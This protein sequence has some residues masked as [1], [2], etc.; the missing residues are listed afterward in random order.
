MYEKECSPKYSIITPMYNSFSKMEL[1]LSSFERQNYRNFEIIIVDDC[2][3]D[4]SYERITEYSKRSTLQLKILKTHKNSGPGSARNIGLKNITSEWVLFIDS[5]DCIE[6]NFFETI[7]DNIEDDV[8]ILLF[9]YYKVDRERKYKKETVRNVLNSSITKEDILL[10]GTTS[11]WGK[12]FRVECIINHD[13]YFPELFRYEDWVF[14]VKVI[15]SA[16]KIK[17]IRKP[18]Y[19]YINY[20][21]SVVHVRDRQGC[22][23]ASKAMNCLD[24]E[25]KKYNEKIREAIYLREIVYISGKQQIVNYNLHNLKNVV[26]KL[27]DEYPNWKNNPYIRSFTK[28]QR[29][30]I[31]IIKT[32]QYYLLKIIGLII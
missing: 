23:F 22:E 8:D 19:D 25:L 16:S 2:S 4:D 7:N 27:E 26:Q 17:Y 3:T 15:G 9:D 29:I 13:V 20:E 5:D 11:V 21:D 30:I 10:W 12:V 18:L 32:K 6:P 1:F 14:L 28:P 31:N 24:S